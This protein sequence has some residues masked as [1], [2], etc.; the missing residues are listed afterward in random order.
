MFFQNLTPNGSKDISGNSD[1]TLPVKFSYANHISA[2]DPHNLSFYQHHICMSANHC[3]AVVRI[4]AVDLLS[5][6]P[7]HNLWHKLKVS[8]GKLGEP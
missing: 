7:T 4:D 5:I 8:W 1:F 3:L 2:F 6:S